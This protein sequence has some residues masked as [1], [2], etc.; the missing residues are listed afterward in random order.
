[1]PADVLTILIFIIIGIGFI[2]NI[3]KKLKEFSNRDTSYGEYTVDMPDPVNNESY[4]ERIQHERDQLRFSTPTPPPKKAWVN[5][6]PVVTKYYRDDS[7]DKKIGKHEAE[8]ASD[9]PVTSPYMTHDKPYVI[10]QDETDSYLTNFLEDKDP[11]SQ[12][13]IMSIILNPP[14]SLQNRSII[15]PL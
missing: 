2:A 6:Q 14:K 4:E 5:P 9:K 12:G 1:M 11:V 10:E 3:F 8:T 7:H 13:I 15:R